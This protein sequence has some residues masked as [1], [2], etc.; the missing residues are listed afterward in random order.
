MEICQL[1]NIQNKPTEQNKSQCTRAGTVLTINAHVVFISSLVL[2]LT[3]YDPKYKCSILRC[4]LHY[5][6]LFPSTNGGNIGKTVLEQ[7]IKHVCYYLFVT[8]WHQG[9]R[10]TRNITKTI[11]K[12]LSELTMQLRDLRNNEKSLNTYITVS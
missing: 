3:D 11:P 1:Q 9:L 5:E 6:V 2:L 12:N 7:H 10:F 4:E 8:T